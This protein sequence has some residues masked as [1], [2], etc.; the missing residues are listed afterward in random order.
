MSFRLMNL[1]KSALLPKSAQISTYLDGNGGQFHGSSKLHSSSNGKITALRGGRIQG[2]QV[3]GSSLSMYFLL[4]SFTHS[5]FYSA[6][7]QIP[8]ILPHASSL[9][10]IQESLQIRG[11]QNYLNPK[12][13]SCSLSKFRFFCTD[14]DSVGSD[15]DVESEHLVDDNPK[16]EID[17]E[18]VERVCR[19]INETFAVDRNME[20]VLDECGVDLNHEL[21]LAVLDRFKHARK[22]AFRF[23]YWAAEQPGFSHDSRTYNAIM[24]VLGKTRQFETM[25]LVLEEM[26]EKGLL[27]METFLIS[28]KAFA[29][30]KERKKAVG[31]F[32]LMKKHKYKVSVETI[33]CLLDA[34][35]RAKLVKEAQVL[36]EKLELKFAP[37]LKTYTVL[38]NGWCTVKNLLEAGRTWNEMIENGFKPDIVA[39]N[40]MIEGLLRINKQSDAVKLFEVM[41]SKGP[42]PNVRSYTILIKYLCK[43]G[44]MKEAVDL[45]TDM[46]NSSCRPDAALYTCLLTGFAKQKKMDMVYQCLEEMREQGCPPDGRTYN[47]LI[48]VMTSQ[49]NPDDA[50]KIYKKMIKNN[51]QPSIHTYNMI[52]KSYFFARDYE[53]GCAAWEEMKK[54]GCCPDDNSYTILIGGL[55]RQGRYDEACKYLEEMIHKGMKAPQIDYRKFSP[56]LSRDGLN[57]MQRLAQKTKLSGNLGLANVF[58]RLQRW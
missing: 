2:K 16:I 47:A 35:G 17:V 25:V 33:N 31:V 52:M 48:K 58:E 37:N 36:F 18:E 57:M 13:L 30:S 1:R 23:F 12:K 39:H 44:H 53:M 10:A 4:N 5:S 32:D 14:V 21:V 19:V 6:R 54:N 29:A 42:P 43:H 20:A 24:N 46:L 22:P 9:C 15:T 38:L 28:M 49:H 41:K 8:F 7:C 34:L 56:A 40:I 51:I 45:L 3:D 55:I 50:V 26:G 11:Q 27:T